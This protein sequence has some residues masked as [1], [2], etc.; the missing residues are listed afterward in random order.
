M[1]TTQETNLKEAWGHE[2]YI[3]NCLRSQEMYRAT[4]VKV[5]KTVDQQIEHISEKAK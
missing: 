5:T 4:T 3:E 1:Q 2:D